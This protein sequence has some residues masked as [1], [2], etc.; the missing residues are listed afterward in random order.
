MAIPLETVL[1]ATSYVVSGAAVLAAA[2][3]SPK[4]EKASKALTF[5]RKVLDFL[6]MNVGN[7]KNAADAAQA[8]AQDK[9]KVK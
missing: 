4:G 3:P 1:E 8:Q 9:Q 5:V 6:A 7:A 2:I